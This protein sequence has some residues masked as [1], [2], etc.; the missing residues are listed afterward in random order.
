MLRVVAFGNRY[1]RDDAIAIEIAENLKSKLKEQCIDVLI[2][3]TDYEF[4]FET[5]N[6]DDYLIILLAAHSK[7]NPGSLQLYKIS[8]AV[9]FYKK[10]GSVYPFSLNIFNLMHLFHLSYSGYIISINVN[11]V[12]FKSGLSKEL[13]DDFTQICRKIELLIMNI[14]NNIFLAK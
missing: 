4:C 10:T 3:N 9:Q 13:E 6:E 2:C 1:K 5:I 7:K 14:R 8:D 11:D 12:S